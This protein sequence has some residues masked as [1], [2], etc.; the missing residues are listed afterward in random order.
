MVP[1]PKLIH[2]LVPNVP[3]LRLEHH[4]VWSKSYLDILK[5]LDVDHWCDGQTNGQMKLR[6][7]N[8]DFT[9]GRRGFS[10]TRTVLPDNNTYRKCR[11]V[12]FSLTVHVL[13]LTFALSV[14]WLATSRRRMLARLATT[15]SEANARLSLCTFTCGAQR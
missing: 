2:F 14:R 4:N 5:R 9:I 3:L 12:V 13:P 1:L 7:K 15:G 6:A 8:D 11:Q 10:R